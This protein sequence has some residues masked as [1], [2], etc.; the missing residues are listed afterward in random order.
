MINHSG[1]STENEFSIETE[2]DLIRSFRLSDQK[3][4]II[5]GG[6]DYPLR[7]RSYLTWRESSG[8]Y[9][10]LVFKM[11]NWDLP[12]GVAFKK[13]AS[14]DFPGGL[15]SWCHSYGTSEDISLLSVAMDVNVSKAYLLCTEISCLEKIEETSARQGKDPGKNIEE[16]YFRMSKLFEGISQYKA[17]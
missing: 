15:C 11:P 5:P 16:L 6:L 4:L 7:V 12:R 14:G 2:E 17:E 1:L 13:T 3:K 9:T 8:V 10:Y